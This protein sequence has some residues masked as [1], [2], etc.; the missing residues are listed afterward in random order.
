MLRAQ[1]SRLDTKVQASLIAST[2]LRLRPR[3]EEGRIRRPTRSRRRRTKQF[4]RAR[5]HRQAAEQDY[6]QPQ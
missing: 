1:P 6:T 2:G 5:E 3:P 4:E